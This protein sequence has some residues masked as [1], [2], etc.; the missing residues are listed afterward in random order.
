MANITVNAFSAGVVTESLVAAAAGGDSVQ[1]YTGKEFLIVKNAHASAARTV[2]ID[3]VEPCSQGS[4][5]NLA[6]TVAALTTRL[7]KLPPPA[8]RWKQTTGEVDITYSDSAADLTIGA[9]LWP[10]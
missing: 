4:D 3:S 1:A 10:E 5:H 9:F 7:I 8:P 6:I 2:T